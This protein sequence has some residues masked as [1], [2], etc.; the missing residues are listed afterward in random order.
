LRGDVD[1]V[2][3]Q[4]SEQADAGDPEDAGRGAAVAVGVCEDPADVLDLDLPERPQRRGGPW[5]T[6]PPEVGG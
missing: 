4:L 2:S 5:P 1:P 6:R 3:T